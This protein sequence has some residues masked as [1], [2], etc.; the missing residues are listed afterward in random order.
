MRKEFWWLKCGT[1]CPCSFCSEKI[2]LISFPFCDLK[3]VATFVSKER[4]N[5]LL[6]QSF[7]F[8]ISGYFCSFWVCVIHLWSF[9][10]DGFLPV[11]LL[12]FVYFIPS[13]QAC[14]QCSSSMPS[15]P[16]DLSSVHYPR[17]QPL[18]SQNESALQR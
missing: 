10:V 16:T 12:P 4:R 13:P 1:V 17:Q 11:V 3:I 9:Y 15:D 7:Y 6:T 2:S 14:A 18:S 8:R 5:S